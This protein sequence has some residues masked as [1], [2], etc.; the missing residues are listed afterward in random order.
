MLIATPPS[1][2]TD[3]TDARARQAPRARGGGVGD[4]EGARLAAGEEAVEEGRRARL[5]EARG[6]HAQ[7]A[8]QHAVARRRR[9]RVRD[10]PGD[11][12][13]GDEAVTSRA[14]W[15]GRA[16]SFS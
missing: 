2:E 1:Y 8:Q 14:L 11:D 7:R 16:S 15:R 9:R 5:Q 13:Q 3:K 4:R 12:R 10:R 6:R